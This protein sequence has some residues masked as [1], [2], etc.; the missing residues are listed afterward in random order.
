MTEER[1]SWVLYIARDP[2][3]VAQIAD[4]MIPAKYGIQH[5]PEHLLPVLEDPEGPEHDALVA[6]I[7]EVPYV[8]A[9]LDIRRVVYRVPLG[10]VPRILKDALDRVGQEDRPPP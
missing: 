8:L 10:Y 7:V 1:P 6:T 5:P 3:H 9:N 4:R 2:Q